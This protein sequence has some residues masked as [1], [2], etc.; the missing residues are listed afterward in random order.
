MSVL[1]KLDHAHG[2]EQALIRIRLF[3]ARVFRSQTPQTQKYDDFTDIQ[4]KLK[5]L[6]RKSSAGKMI[7]CA[8]LT[9]QT[10]IVLKDSERFLTNLPVELVVEVLKNLYWRDVLNV[11]RV[12]G[13]LIQICV[14]I[15]QVIWSRRANT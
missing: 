10:N 8:R 6:A 13:V 5:T 7:S 2:T 11:R 9:L 12:S 4:A 3:S 14:R 15:A 1:T